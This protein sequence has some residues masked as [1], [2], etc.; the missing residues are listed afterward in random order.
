MQ[1]HSWVQCL[2]GHAKPYNWLILVLE[3]LYLIKLPFCAMHL[4]LLVNVKLYFSPLFVMQFCIL[5]DIISMCCVLLKLILKPDIIL[6]V[7]HT[8]AECMNNSNDLL[9]KLQF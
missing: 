8:Y 1:Y 9:S 5:I 2:L 4:R 7:L 3:D 6:C